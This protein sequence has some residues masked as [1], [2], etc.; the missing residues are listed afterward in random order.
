MKYYTPPEGAER[1]LRSRIRRCY[2]ALAELQQAVEKLYNRRSQLNGSYAVNDVV[3]MRERCREAAHSLTDTADL[4]EADEELGIKRAQ[5]Q[6]LASPSIV[7]GICRS[8]ESV[9]DGAKTAIRNIEY[10]LDAGTAETTDDVY[11]SIRET[12]I[13]ILGLADVILDAID[14]GFVTDAKIYKQEDR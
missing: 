12:V 4:E 2:V 14:S 10:Q 13:E 6:L 11:Q 9:H 1:M 8:I 3:G 5:K 7:D